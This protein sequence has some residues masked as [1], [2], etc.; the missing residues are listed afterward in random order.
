MS[1]TLD[2]YDVLRLDS[3]KSC[4]LE[5]MFISFGIMTPLVFHAYGIPGN[6]FLPM[7]WAVYCAG[8]LYGYRVGVFT[9]L[10]IP[11]VNFLITGMPAIA[12]LP[13]IT[14]ELAVYGLI[15]GILRERTKLSTTSIIAASMLSG[16]LSYLIIAASLKG[17]S[18]ALPFVLNIWK[19]GA[20]STIAQLLLIPVIIKLIKGRM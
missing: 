14:A 19:P 11:I 6:V 7:H 10:F 3:F 18:Q 5:L 2:N 8:I 15:S 13:F 1:K 16:R 20:I 4:I 9:G 17:F 12:V